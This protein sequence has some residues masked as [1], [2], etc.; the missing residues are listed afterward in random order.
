MNLPELL[1]LDV[2]HG[3]CAI[4]LDTRGIV[5]I[6][7]APGPTL[8]DT[9]AQLNIREI[10]SLL[11]SHADS[12]HLGGAI[13]ILANPELS[14]QKIYINPDQSRK[15]EAWIDFRYAVRD[16]KGRGTK[17]ETALTTEQTGKIQAGEVFIE[18][19][20]PSPEIALGGVGGTDLGHNKLSPNSM[21][22]VIG[23]VHKSHR[24]AILPGDL[25]KIGLENIDK[26]E[27]PKIETDILIFP[28]HG[29]APGSSAPKGFAQ[30]VCNLTKPKVVIFSI[31]RNKYSNPNDEI[32]LGIKSVVPEVHI[33]C[34]QLSS[35]CMK[36]LEAGPGHLVDV[37]ARGKKLNSCCAGSIVI[38][39]NGDKLDYHPRTE[40]KEFV[41]N[42]IRRVG[43]PR[44]LL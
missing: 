38:K 7:C 34:T 18:V 4:L 26:L 16:A 17:V 1:V 27:T 3:S 42:K 22:V 35:Q 11:I 10:N 5:I 31:D 8:P 20:A 28:H 9:L 43:T 2:G 44:C 19:L 30:K 13:G 12:D 33:M 29:G 40:H 21:S 6:D 32:I 14:I 37:P 25:D 41:N 24:I 39:I 36:T 15:G 23:L